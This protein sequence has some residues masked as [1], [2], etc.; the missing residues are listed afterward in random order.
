MYRK[1]L[2]CQFSCSKVNHSFGLLVV[3]NIYKFE[4]CLI[5]VK[6][7]YYKND[8]ELYGTAINFEIQFDTCN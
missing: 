3:N 2:C 4:S 8:K 5:L 6:N 1:I 7:N